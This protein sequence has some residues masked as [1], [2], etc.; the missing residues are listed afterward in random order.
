LGVPGGAAASAACWASSFALRLFT[1][2]R[3]VSN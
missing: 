3:C 2:L 1:L